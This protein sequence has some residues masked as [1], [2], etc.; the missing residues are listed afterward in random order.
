MI[1]KINQSLARGE[2]MAPPSKSYA[3]R[4]LIGAALAKGVSIIK[5]IGRFLPS[6]GYPQYHWWRGIECI[7]L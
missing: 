4:L 5:N 2:V 7:V 6:H 3:H 1:I